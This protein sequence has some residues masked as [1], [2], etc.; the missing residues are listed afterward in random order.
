MFLLCEI[1]DIFCEF[2]RKQDDQRC[3]YKMFSSDAIIMISSC[4]FNAFILR[5]VSLGSCWSLQCDILICCFSFI[6]ITVISSCV[7]N[8]VTLRFP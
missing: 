2:G 1:V 5:R 4:V 7:F 6:S 3:A 8:V